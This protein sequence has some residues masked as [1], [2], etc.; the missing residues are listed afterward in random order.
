MFRSLSMP[1][2]GTSDDNVRTYANGITAY[3]DGS[4]V[5]GSSE[6]RASWLRS[7]EGGKLKVTTGNLLPW[8]TVTGN[9]NDPTDPTSPFMEDAEGN[10]PKHF[11]AGD[12]R[13][14]ENPLL[15]AVHTLFVREHN[16]LA[17]EIAAENPGFNDEELY[18][19]A[20]KKVTI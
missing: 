8:N 2:S 6:S 19:A 7:Y 3:I 4:A 5:Y 9:F 12:V 20:R 14:N 1:G 15:A 16:R 18:E 11:I 10:G 17:D 13:A